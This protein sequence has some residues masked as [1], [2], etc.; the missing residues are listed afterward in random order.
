MKSTY[1]PA[2]VASAL[3]FTS[4]AA[5]AAEPDYSEI[6]AKHVTPAIEAELF[7]GAVIGIYKDG[8]ASFYP[9]GTLN[10][11][12]DE[13]PSV[14]TLYEIGSISKVI[15]GTLFADAVRRGEVTRDTLVND[16]LP[17]GYEVKAVDGEDLK[18]WHLTTHSSGWG[19]APFNLAPADGEKPFS[20]YTQEMLFEATKLMPMKQK[21]GTKFEYSNYAVGMLGTLI[22]IN[23]NGEYEAL[24]KERILEPLD[25]E[26]FTIQLAPDQQSML[27]PATAGGRSTKPWGK[28]GPMDPCGMWVTNAPGL[29]DFA[30]A[31]ITGGDFDIHESLA[32]SR[33][34]LFDPGAGGKICS[35]W[36]IAADSSTYWH[37]GMTGG[38]S[39]Y[40]A[41]NPTH[42]TAVVILANGAAFETTAIGAKI[43]QAVF[44]MNPAPIQVDIAEKLDEAYTDQL[45]GV[46]KS[47]VGFDMIVSV[48]RGRLFAQITGQQALEVVSVSKDR[49]RYKL[50]DAEIGFDVPEDGQASRVTLFQNGMEIKCERK[51]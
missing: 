36:F 1:T 37:N 11:D 8:E 30:I 25:I 33:E 46:Y 18:L 4:L 23:A 42:D 2:I 10:F 19:T 44:G 34:P 3:V 32:M 26:N 21:P 41:V 28:T 45:V 38:Y 47:A 27:A 29:M 35:G 16:L 22:S 14:C 17:D 39:S 31:N 49:F 40:M 13:S 43:I 5:F 48:S 24:V 9:I 6:V 12:Q 20:G 7:P 50:V 51:E 15:T